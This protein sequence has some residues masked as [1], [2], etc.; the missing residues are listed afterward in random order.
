MIIRFTIALAAAASAATA[1]TFPPDQIDFF[2][3]QIEEI[4]HS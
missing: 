1:A 3:K 2:E 4:T